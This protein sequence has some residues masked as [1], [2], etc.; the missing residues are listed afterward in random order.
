MSVSRRYPQ[1]ERAS[2]RSMQDLGAL[3]KPVPSTTEEKETI[4]NA[5][6]ASA[7]HIEASPEALAAALSEFCEHRAQ[8]VQQAAEAAAAAK[9]ANDTA[10]HLRSSVESRHAASEQELKAI[11]EQIEEL[12]KASATPDAE[13]PKRPVYLR[14]LDVAQ[15]VGGLA[16]FA[17]GIFLGGKVVYDQVQQRLGSNDE[18]PA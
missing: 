16:A 15:Q 2:A 4:V 18:L 9:Q 11:K 1:G 8:V 3:L 12:K 7:T 10:S 6:P 17:G 5:N 14:A 13:K